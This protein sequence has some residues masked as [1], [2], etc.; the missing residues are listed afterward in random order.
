MASLD[1]HAVAEDTTSRNDSRDAVVSARKKRRAARTALACN[2]CRYIQTFSVVTIGRS[3]FIALWLPRDGIVKSLA[4]QGFITFWTGSGRVG[5][6]ANGLHVQPAPDA[7][8][9]VRIQEQNLPCHPRGFPMP[10]LLAI[11]VT[12][13]A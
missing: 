1:R 4:D 2:N 7:S 6:R 12:S 13:A 3:L 8:R 10:P 11:M 5:A 9:P